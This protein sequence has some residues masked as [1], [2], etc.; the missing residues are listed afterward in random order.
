MKTVHAY[1][2]TPLEAADVAALAHVL[3]TGGSLPQKNP[4]GEA[5]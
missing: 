1:A 2:G 5:L 4:D 3:R